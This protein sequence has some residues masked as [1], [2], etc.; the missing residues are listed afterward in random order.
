MLLPTGLQPW[1][2]FRHST[3]DKITM[4]LVRARN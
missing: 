3:E 4:R 1:D 2:C